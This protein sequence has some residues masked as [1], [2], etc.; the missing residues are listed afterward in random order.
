M[1]R[2]FRYM[3]SPITSANEMAAEMSTCLNTQKY[4]I[5]ASLLGVL[6]ACICLLVYQL[7]AQSLLMEPLRLGHVI[8]DGRPNT[9]AVYVISRNLA[10]LF[11]AF[12]AFSNASIW[13]LATV[14]LYLWATVFSSK[15][16][17]RLL[18]VLNAYALAPVALVSLISIGLLLV[19]VFL[20]TDLFW[21]G[22][23]IFAIVLPAEDY[24]EYARHIPVVEIC[25]LLNNAAELWMLGL[26]A[27]NTNRTQRI[28]AFLSI[29]GVCLFGA[30]LFTVSWYIGQS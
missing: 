20:P 19:A 9:D 15:T 27:V 11:T 28:S 3:Y 30:L 18:F 2:I 12:S 10:S 21:G 24:V 8:I 13:V 25:R 17:F 26:M 7:L 23:S 6:A 1:K 14:Y 16:D 4:S 29:A 5:R 22:D